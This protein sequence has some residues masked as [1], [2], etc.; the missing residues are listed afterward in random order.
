M[1]EIERE[2]RSFRIWIYRLDRLEGIS[3]FPDQPEAGLFLSFDWDGALYGLLLGPGLPKPWF[4]SSWPSL[5]NSS[6]LFMLSGPKMKS[7]LNVSVHESPGLSTT[8]STG[9]SS[10]GFTGLFS[11]SLLHPVSKKLFFGLFLIL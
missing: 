6:N 10:S 7:A 3:S 2:K 5:S 8:T 11:G 4:A 9:N 1:R